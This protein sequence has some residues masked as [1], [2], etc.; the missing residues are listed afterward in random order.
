MKIIPNIIIN[1]MHS[2]VSQYPSPYCVNADAGTDIIYARA[3]AA[4]INFNEL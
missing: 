1:K 2:V 4:A 3:K